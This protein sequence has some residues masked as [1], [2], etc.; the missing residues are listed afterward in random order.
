MIT[1]LPPVRSIDDAGAP[2][3]L[4]SALEA[5]RADGPSAEALARMAQR[6]GLPASA[7]TA[8]S[9]DGA[10]AASALSV[11]GRRALLPCVALLCALGGWS[12]HAA[13][14]PAPDVARVARTS[15]APSMQPP[16]TA[17]PAAPSPPPLAALEPASTALPEPLLPSRAA[18]ARTRKHKADTAV[19][20]PAPNE[21]LALLARAQAQLIP[22]PR[23]A[24]ALAEEHAR[25]FPEGVFR[26]ERELIAIVG[27]LNSGD[28][29]GARSRADRFERAFPASVHTARLQSLIADH[30]NA[31]PDAPIREP[32][33]SRLTGDH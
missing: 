21:E 1:A 7:S 14:A 26:E 15:Q 27:L 5:G 12:L 25:R 31:A 33:A 18:P 2:P 24:L 10:A 13:L 28:L 32:A 17:A 16:A 20:V 4:R 23:R 8:A 11:W 9:S 19:A 29:R 30:K 22:A 3:A 6:L